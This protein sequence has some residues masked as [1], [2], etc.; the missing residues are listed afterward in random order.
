MAVVSASVVLVTYQIDPIMTMILLVI[1]PI[2]VSIL[3]G[4]RLFILTLLFL[5]ISF[6]AFEGITQI[7]MYQISGIDGV[8]LIDVIVVAM[9]LGLLLLKPRLIRD[10]RLVQIYLP[11]I[12]IMLL[13][14][15]FSPIIASI[16]FLI[17]ILAPLAAYIMVR[18]VT[19]TPADIFL[20]LKTIIV[21]S[22][23]PIF[24]AIYQLIANTAPFLGGYSRLVG[25]F[26]SP[27]PVGFSLYL[28]IIIFVVYG[29][30]LW[31]LNL[32]TIPFILLLVVI[33]YLTYT[34]GA[35][36]GMILGLALIDILRGKRLRIVLGSAI[37]FLL[38]FTVPGWFTRFSELISTIGGGGEV[39]D[40][41]FLT[42]L[43]I[44]KTLIPYALQS[45]LLGNGIGAS[46]RIFALFTGIKVAPHNDYL[47][48]LVEL[49]VL[50]LLCY[51]FIQS[52]VI[53]NAWKIKRS[54]P[55]SLQSVPIVALVSYLII[56]VVLFFE[57]PIFF[58]GVQ[59]ILLSLVALT[60]NLARIHRNKND[61]FRYQ[62][63]ISCR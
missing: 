60:D 58:T 34:R 56:N 37:I 62:S 63:K 9:G 59:I 17:R 1:T 43:G 22:V 49:G 11:F 14:S 7:E 52:Y 36:F 26:L 50:G 5:R 53:F 38:I 46:A 10:Y 23:I 24:L 48:L 31:R 15:L 61:V 3:G 41:S 57:N 8:I 25:P 21:A 39:T 54:L 19:R 42:R 4:F 28:L 12:I 51:V 55:R 40:F 13:V 33:M 18:F 30:Y 27:S 32:F 2:A 44:Q 29:I 35:I 47:Y 45:P 6:E 16:P 20:I